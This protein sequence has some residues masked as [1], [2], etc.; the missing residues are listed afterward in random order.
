VVASRLADGTPCGLT[1]N[2]VASVSLDPPLILVSVSRESRTLPHI[3]EDGTFAVSVLDA[4]G[5]AL[6]RRFSSPE[7]DGRFDGVAHRS[8]VTGSPVLQSALAWTDCR[9]HALHEAGDHVILMGEVLEC[10]ARDGD[11]LLFFRGAYQAG[12]A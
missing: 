5:E 3:L 7:S 8:E 4:D 12:R 10:D 9:I 2:A 11:P 1:A 6:A